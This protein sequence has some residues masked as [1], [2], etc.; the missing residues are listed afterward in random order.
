MH[1]RIS[2]VDST[3]EW[4][5]CIGSFCC[6]VTEPVFMQKGKKLCLLR[7]QWM[8][9]NSWWATKIP[10]SFRCPPKLWTQI[11][12]ARSQCYSLLYRVHSNR[13]HLCI[14]DILCSS[15]SS[16]PRNPFAKGL[17]S[18]LSWVIWKEKFGE[19]ASKVFLFPDHKSSV[20]QAK[21]I[22]IVN[23]LISKTLG[24]AWQH[25]I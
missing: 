6:E 25:Y 10:R 2:V 19:G 22:I 20:E 7:K 18:I 5:S 3:G 17:F 8:R 14:L 4:Q 13:P 23:K 24:H 11:W 9:F 1:E 15:I 12:D 21:E 16:L